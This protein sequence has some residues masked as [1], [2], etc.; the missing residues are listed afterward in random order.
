MKL[1]FTFLEVLLSLQIIL[2]LVFLFAMQM[3]SAIINSSD[4]SVSLR[5]NLAIYDL[6]SQLQ[7]NSSLSACVFQNDE[8]CI[9]KVISVYEKAFRLKSIRLRTDN[10]SLGSSAPAKILNCLILRSANSS[11]LLCISIGA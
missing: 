9:L 3:N 2:F 6:A 1:Q 5:E 4:A 11:K 10:L 8:A 7:E